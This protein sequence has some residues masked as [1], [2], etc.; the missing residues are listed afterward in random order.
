M[1][2]VNKITYQL[3]KNVFY[4][5]IASFASSA[6]LLTSPKGSVNKPKASEAKDTISI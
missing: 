5:L 2:R 4:F 3:A 6:L 1:E